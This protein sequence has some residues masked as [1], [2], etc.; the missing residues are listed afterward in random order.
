MIIIKD[1]SCDSLVIG[2]T[3]LTRHDIEIEVRRYF[4]RN[5]IIDSVGITKMNLSHRNS[6]IASLLMYISEEYDVNIIIDST[7]ANSLSQNSDEF[8]LFLLDL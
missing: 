4:E 8:K 7:I 2:H 5:N 6:P 1:L 3:T